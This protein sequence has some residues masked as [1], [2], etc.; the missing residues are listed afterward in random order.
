MTSALRRAISLSQPQRASSSV[1]FHTQPAQLQQ[2]MDADAAQR[3]TVVSP[4]LKP[5]GPVIRLRSAP[6]RQ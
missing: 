5:L 2:P 1:R 3:L 6:V 4:S